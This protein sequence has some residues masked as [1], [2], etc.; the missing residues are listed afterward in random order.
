MRTEEFVRKVVDVVKESGS[1]GRVA[2]IDLE[3]KILSPTDFLS[4][5]RVL[6]AGVS[7]RTGDKVTTK[8]ILLAQDTDEAESALLEQLGT[9]LASINPLVLAGYNISGYDF[10]LLC[11]KLKQYEGFL[12][13]KLAPGEKPVY[14]KGYWALKDALTRS[15]ILDVMH[16]ARFEIAARDNTTAKYLKLS[17]VLE[18]A[19]FS[20]LPLMKKKHL[21]EGTAGD[22]ASKGDKIWRMWLDKDPKLLEYLE[23]DTHDTLLVTERLFGVR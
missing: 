14:P 19:M 21:A 18:H 20:D 9:V 1:W 2:S 12:R 10:P 5:E 23:A 4:N 7:W 13:A 8:T 22:S 17:A 16:A 15:F 3:T 11:L 6:A